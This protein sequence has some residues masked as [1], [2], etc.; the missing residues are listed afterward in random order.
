MH[1]V[2]KGVL[3]AALP[4][5]EPK[6]GLL[7]PGQGLMIRQ[8]Q[9]VHAPHLIPGPATTSG[10][11]KQ[12]LFQFRIAPETEFI[13]FANQ[14]GSIVLLVYEKHKRH[15]NWKT[16]SFHTPCTFGLCYEAPWGNLYRA[17]FEYTG[18][19]VPEGLRGF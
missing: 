12:F 8:A 16:L 5:F 4:E 10:L 9:P 17:A 3:F 6:C 18:A 1:F 15:Q 11:T 13:G 7:I 19:A 14:H 2:K